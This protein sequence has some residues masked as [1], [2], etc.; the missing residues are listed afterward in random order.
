MGT[1]C[2]CYVRLR[3][4]FADIRTFADEDVPGAF[5]DICCAALLPNLHG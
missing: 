5:L 3:G 4:A 1:L 2:C